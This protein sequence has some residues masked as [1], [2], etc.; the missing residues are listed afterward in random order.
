MHTVITIKV[1]SNFYHNKN[2]STRLELF[3]ANSIAPFRTLL[4]KPITHAMK[5]III[6]TNLIEIKTYETE[7]I[8]TN[9]IKR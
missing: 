5:Q 9:K 7:M 6:K 8:I 3:K 1:G 2:Y 4:I